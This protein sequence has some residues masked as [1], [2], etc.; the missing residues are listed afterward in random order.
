M[1]KKRKNQTYRSAKKNKKRKRKEKK[2]TKEERQAK[3]ENERGGMDW[4]EKK[5]KDIIGFSIIIKAL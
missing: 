4:N 1:L 5:M 3:Y 2:H